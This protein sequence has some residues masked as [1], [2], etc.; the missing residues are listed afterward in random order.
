MTQPSWAEIWRELRENL[1]SQRRCPTHP[2]YPCV[3]TLSRGKVNDVPEVN[4]KG[5]RLR[6]DKTGKEDF[7]R[8]RQFEAWWHYLVDHGYASLDPESSNCPD[9]D[10]SR[11]VGAILVTCLPSRIKRDNKDRAVI[12]LV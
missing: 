8:A 4:E 2:D 5:I 10:R 6:S 7:I 12:R 11:I 3:K 1:K 9:A